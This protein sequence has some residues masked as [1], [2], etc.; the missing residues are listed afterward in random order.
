MPIRTATC[1]AALLPALSLA[2][3]LLAAEVRGEGSTPSRGL[4]TELGTS[5]EERGVEDSTRGRMWAT[6]LRG[7][8]EESAEFE[9]EFKSATDRET[10]ELLKSF[11]RIK[12]YSL[13]KRIADMLRTLSL[14]NV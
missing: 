8:A 4:G 14:K 1:I 12:D 7:M 5:R 11:K 3:P 2:T 13:R 10:L 6:E 9:G